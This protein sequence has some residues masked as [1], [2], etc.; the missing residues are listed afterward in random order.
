[1]V[2]IFL[3]KVSRFLT[4][5][6]CVPGFVACVS[7]S[8]SDNKAG[9]TS[10]NETGAENAPCPPA[11]SL[12][13]TKCNANNSR[14]N[15]SQNNNAKGERLRL[16]VPASLRSA[17]R[18]L[19]DD[20]NNVIR[21]HSDEIMQCWTSRGRARFKGTEK[22][23]AEFYIQP[24]GKV[25]NTQI[26]SDISDS[27]SKTLKCIDKRILTWKFPKRENERGDLVVSHVFKFS[28]R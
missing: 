5:L 8:S 6:V 4:L 27:G 13:S 24:N 25:A 15:N 26:K 10:N 11:R 19:Q 7:Q 17:N 12:F 3:T 21:N 22:V 14:N 28:Y 23:T 9:T 16:L 2:A 18:N 20:V 1:M